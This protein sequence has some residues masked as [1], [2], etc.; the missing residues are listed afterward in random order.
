MA[1]VT[2]TSSAVVVAMAFNSLTK[3]IELNLKMITEWLILSCMPLFL[4]PG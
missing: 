1:Y 3:V 4:C 2:A